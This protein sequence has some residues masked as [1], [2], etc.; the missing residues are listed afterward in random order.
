[1]FD[2]F[3][4]LKMA[5]VCSQ[6]KY[7]ALI[8][9]LRAEPCTRQEL[10]D[11]IFASK[12]RTI[13]LLSLLTA[14]VDAP[15]QVRIC[16]WLRDRGGFCPVYELGTKPDARKPKRRTPKERHHQIQANPEAKRERNHKLMVA[17]RKRRQ[18][19]HPK[20]LGQALSLV[21]NLRNGSTPQIAKALGVAFTTAYATLRDLEAENKIMR[22]S[23][24]R[25]VP[26]CWGLYVE[27]A[28]PDTAPKQKLTQAWKAPRMKPQGVFAA[29]GLP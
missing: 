9:T 4:P 16:R 20:L 10:Q 7:D 25:A 3:I 15:R 6:R 14:E 13:Q 29:L 28:T 22:V 2:E 24:D 18:A 1:M 21:T 23:P 12:T 27:D 17:R 11:R 19:R 8:E 5:T 26:I